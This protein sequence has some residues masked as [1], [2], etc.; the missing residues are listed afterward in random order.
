MKFKTLMLLLLVVV[1]PTALLSWGGFQLARQQSEQLE[2]RLKALMRDQLAELDSRVQRYFSIQEAAL[3]QVTS[4]SYPTLDSIR[5]TTAGV[6]IVENLFIISANGALA[7]PNPLSPLNEREREFHARIKTIVDDGEIQNQIRQLGGDLSPKRKSAA[8][9]AS[10]SRQA[11]VGSGADWQAPSQ[12]AGAA[13][14]PTDNNPR[15]APNPLAPRQAASTAPVQQEDSDPP[16]ELAQSTAEPSNLVPPNDV[17]ASGGDE[18]A[19]DRYPVLEGWFVWYWGRGVNLIFWQRL[20]SGNIVCVALERS[21][22]MADLIAEL[23]DSVGSR[24]KLVAE[25]NRLTRLINSSGETVYQWGG[26]DEEPTILAA[27][28]PVSHPL[29]SWKL[30]M[31]V[32]PAELQ[33][34]SLAG[35][36]I[37]FGIVAFALALIAVAWIFFR[38]YSRD[39]REA[40]KRVSFVNQ[41]SHELRTPLTNIR[42]YAELLKQEIDELDGL[43]AEK[44]RKRIDVVESE[45]QRLSRLITNVLSFAGSQKDRLDLRRSSG[46]IDVCIEAVVSSFVPQLERLGIEVRRDLQ[47]AE[48]VLFDADA[49]GQIV[50]NLISNVEKYAADGKYV[51]IQSRQEPGWATIR[52]EDDGR[53]IES[54]YATKIF[55][56]FWRLSDEPRHAS[57]TG[58]GLSISRELAQIHGG[59][60]TLEET[61]AGAC[62]VIRIQTDKVAGNESSGS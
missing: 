3:Q 12:N 47:A 36:N 50:G 9:Q 57:G 42:M 49:L 20:A 14:D 1:L 61:G 15:V 34:Q 39:L 19:N 2:N 52:I 10:I 8:R 37:A 51:A 17:A 62:F 54:R 33:G 16:D 32:A 22:W 56:P 26:P 45:S 41:V 30:Q 55:E 7:Y 43:E 48:P 44:A 31:W 59:D 60:L 53:G 35:L 38:E 25:R 27:E 18:T 11:S 5:E 23:P 58:I 13:A 29:T 24:Q 4:R 6:G 21:R 40:G 46:V 28:I